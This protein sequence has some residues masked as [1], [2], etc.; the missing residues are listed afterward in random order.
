[1]MWAGSSQPTRRTAA[2]PTTAGVVS[3]CG[4][5]A[6]FSIAAQLQGRGSHD[7]LHGAGLLAALLRGQTAVQF[8]GVCALSESFLVAGLPVEAAGQAEPQRQAQ[9]VR[10]AMRGQG[11]RASTSAST[12]RPCALRAKTT[13]LLAAAATSRISGSVPQAAARTTAAPSASHSA[14][15]SSAANCW[16]W[17]ERNFRV[18][19]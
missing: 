14:C 1:M 11:S 7:K 4:P 18:Y 15:R 3:G 13:P 5:D 12:W 2:L 19:Q 10:F 6:G 8:V 17:S 16:A 9:P